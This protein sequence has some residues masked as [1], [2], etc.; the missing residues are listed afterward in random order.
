MATIKGWF[1][2]WFTSLFGTVAGVPQIIEGFTSVPKN[3][4]LVITGVGT[5]LLGL[6]AK[7][8]NVTGGSVKQ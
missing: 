5:L 3:W 8:G 7:D 6:F 1:T 4:P 2:S